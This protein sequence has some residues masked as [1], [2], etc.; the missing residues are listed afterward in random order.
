MC[1]RSAPSDPR[2][3]VR[4]LQ[5][6][7]AKKSGTAAVACSRDGLVGCNSPMH[8]YVI[9]RRTLL[10]AATGAAAQVCAWGIPGK[11]YQRALARDDVVSSILAIPG[12]GAKPTEA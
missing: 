3:A 2:Q 4:K 5:R 12:D 8:N 9:D 7:P 10:K 6:E 1:P 11:S